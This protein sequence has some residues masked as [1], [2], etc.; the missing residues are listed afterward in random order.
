M[1]GLLASV[2][3]LALN[4]Q[5]MGMLATASPAPLPA[6]CRREGKHRCMT[7]VRAALPD[8]P[9]LAVPHK[10]CP[11]FPQRAVVSHGGGFRAP[12]GFAF[13]ADVV[14]H[15]ADHSQT[16]ARQSVSLGRSHQKRGP[17]SFLS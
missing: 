11:Q 16:E 8:A 6:C 2:L 14:S 5:L 9:A 17:P 7:R 13:F 15:P 10:V 3:A 4:G 12:A 1:R